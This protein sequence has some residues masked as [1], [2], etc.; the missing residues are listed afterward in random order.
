MSFL[1]DVISPVQPVRAS[2]NNNSNNNGKGVSSGFASRNDNLD[3][4]YVALFWLFLH[5]HAATV[6]SLPMLLLHLQRH[7]HAYF[8]L[9]FFSV[10]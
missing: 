10:S 5:F 1:Q 6:Q 4:R 7:L 2:L 9:Y 3:D 8:F